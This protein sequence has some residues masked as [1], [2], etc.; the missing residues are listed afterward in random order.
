[1]KLVHP[2]YMPFT[3]DSGC[4]VVRH[5]KFDQQRTRI[6][7]CVESAMSAL[8]EAG[9]KSSVQLVFLISDGRIER[10]SRSALRRLIRD[11]MERN[12]LLA[13]I[14]VEGG[15]K[16]KDSILSMKEVTFENGKPIV[17]RFIEDYPFPYYIVLDDVATLPEVLG[18]ALKQWFEMLTQLQGP[19]K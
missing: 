2:F 5:F 11:M 1:M 10:D 19:G 12:I 16:K 7:L 8:E 4:D 13:M 17:K 9:D 18:D 15:Q 3:S 14:I 6:A